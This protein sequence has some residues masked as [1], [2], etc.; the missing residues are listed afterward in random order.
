MESPD[1]FR[2]VV[3]VTSSNW[4][5]DLGT[6]TECYAQAGVPAY[7]VVDR[8]HDEVLLHTGPEDGKY[9]VLQRFERGQSVPVPEGVGVR[10]ELPAGTLLD[11]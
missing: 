5:D 3:E 2:M 4:A 11:G 1:V 8:K 10:V 9:S 6:R 7:L